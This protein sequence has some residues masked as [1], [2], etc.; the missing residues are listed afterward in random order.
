MGQAVD[1]RGV[2]FDKDGTLFDF[3]RSWTSV[4]GEAANR[5]ARGDE[6]LARHLM[7]AAGYDVSSGRIA[8]GSIFAAGD[9]QD[10][11]D[12][13]RPHLSAWENDDLVRW[14]DALFAEMGPVAS[15]PVTDL[16]VFFARLKERGL[17]LGIATNDS[18][19]SAIAA[20]ARFDFGPQLSFCCGYDSGHGSKPGPGMVQAFCRET[21]LEASSVAV[22]G[23]NTH[24][25]EMARAAGA[26]LAVGVLTGA[27]GRDDLMPFA[28]MVIDNIAVLPDSLEDYL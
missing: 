15:V 17:V 3:H 14:L 18:Y 20:V 26:G 1:I 13:W 24:D 22:V 23:D 8:A 2:L 27:S 19:A 6:A 21:G 25:L 4:F 10:L 7:V 5:L 11:A 16:A 9:T 28:D 12:A